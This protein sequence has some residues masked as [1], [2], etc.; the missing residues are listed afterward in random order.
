MPSV[1][2]GVV[3]IAILAG[4]F[5]GAFVLPLRY[6]R[7]WGWENTWLVFSCFSLILLP[8]MAAF[9]FVPHLPSLLQA[10]P[11][12]YFLPGL[13]AGSFW[14][15]S[16]V[17][18]G[19]GLDMLGIAV[20]NAVVASMSATAGTL[21][22]LIVYAPD[23]LLTS[24]GLVLIAAIVLIVSGIY[25]YGKAGARKERETAGQQAST[26][27]VRGSFR[28]G[29]TICLISGSMGTVFI[30]GIGSSTGLLRATEAAGTN[31]VFIGCVPMA[32][33]F[34]V[35]FIANLIYCLYRLRQNRT[36]ARFTNSGNFL[37]NT[38]LAF[39][40]AAMWVLALLLYGAAAA[41]MGRLG[42][43]VGFSLFVSGTILFANFLGWRAGEWKGASPST[44]RDFVKGM[45]LV[46]IAI[47]A[48]AF[49]V[50]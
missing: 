14:G 7:N 44:V 22:P 29:L 2:L 25:T 19:L 39:S 30:Y 23:K 8:W 46:V 41:K 1:F 36:F 33:T 27:R 48:I 15:V 17:L 10:A 45:I 9:L 4:F 50:H 26:P 43:S 28:A 35:G 11:L 34:S 3:A 12:T 40:M 24:T 5:N 32:V 37:R 42:P 16:L 20:G 18:Y 38:L 21:G 6:A 47:F 31:P 13:I 49:G